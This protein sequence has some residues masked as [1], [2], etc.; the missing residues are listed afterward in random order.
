MP[1]WQPLSDDV[2]KRAF[3][4]HLEVL[5]ALPPGSVTRM[6]VVAPKAGEAAQIFL[7][8]GVR[9]RLE[10]AH[11]TVH[12]NGDVTIAATLQRAGAQYSVLSTIGSEASF[13]TWT[14]PQGSFRFES[15]GTEGW[16]VE[17]DHPQLRVEDIDSHAVGVP[18][19]PASDAL[20]TFK[21]TTTIIDVMFI[22]SAGIAERYPG[23]IAQTRMN[24]LV[25]LANQHFANS[26]IAAV[27]RLAAT[28]QTSYSDLDGPNAVALD[29]MRQALGGL[30][31]H[32]AFEQLEAQRNAAGADI[33]VF[34]RPHDIETRGNCGIAMFPTGSPDV[35][36]HIVSDGFS[37]WSL[38]GDE[39]F[40]HELG[41]NLGAEHQAGANS[42]N[43]GFGT[44]HVV[45]GQFNTVMGSIGSGNPDRNRRLL[46]FSNPQQLCGG[47]PCGQEGVSDNAR[48]I[49]G[50]LA[51]VSGY[52][53]PAAGAPVVEAPPPLD[54]DPDG[55]GVPD[56]QDAFP[57]DARYHSDRDGD[58]VP[59][60]IDTFPDNAAEWADTDGDGIGDNADPDRDGDGVPNAQD[61]F[62]LDS[63]EWQDS[64]GDGVGDNGD[65]F[66][67]DRREWRD[68]DGDGIGDNADSDR[69]GDGVADFHAGSSVAQTD[70]LVVS[71]GTEKVLRFEGNSGLYAGV[72]IAESHVPQ[73]FGTQSNLAWN[74]HQKKLYAL[75]SSELRRYDRASRQRFDRFLGA[76]PTQS[77]FGLPSGFPFG[78]S[79][80]PDGTVLLADSSSSTLWKRDAITGAALGGGVFGTPAF[81][82]QPPRGS[83]LDGAGRLWTLERDGR[84]S[85]VDP[86]TG[87]LL[88]RFTLR[89]VTPPLAFDPMAMVVGPDGR[90]LFIS[91]AR[92]H[93]VLR[94]DPD[95]PDT[96]SVFVAS[97]AGGL[98]APTGLAFGA[99]GHLLVSSSGSDQILRFD[100]ATGAPLGVFSVAPPGALQQP[101]ALLVVP[102]VAD[103]F[104]QDAQRRFRPIAGGWSNPARSGHGLDL[105]ASGSQ[106]GM[107]WYTYDVDGRP[108]WYLGTGALIGDSWTAP[109]L[110]FRWQD[111]AAVSSVVGSVS[112]QFSSERNAVFS[113]VL[114]DSS[115]SE[116]MRP[117][118][119][120]LS[121]ETQY[122]S[123]AW[124]NPQESGWGLS[125]TQQGDLRYAMAFVYD[126][127]G[128]PVWFAGAATDPADPLRIDMQ[129]FFG[130]DRC[131]TCS[132]PRN[133][134]GQP[135]GF[136]S[137]DPQSPGTVQIDADLQ[138]GEVSWLREALQLQRLTDTPT[139]EN[140]DP[141][142]E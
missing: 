5:E 90:S 85:E 76:D 32:G 34:L 65:A 19:K 105:Q 83:A 113:W 126:D 127:D 11:R 38:C 36:V 133:A 42:P 17:L 46:R 110:R 26:D 23:S 69:D 97:V 109:L 10:A 39:V 31:T 137:F 98:A 89:V 84:L 122:P 107:V 100:G 86:A 142:R 6:Q 121:S 104:P 80:L 120:G 114:P 45:P 129:W 106:L 55:D 59:D 15:A 37:S 132:G 78:L 67:A 3:P 33:V 30:V 108:L 136:L 7:P 60:E 138:F 93:R 68:T 112:L 96:S 71:A 115:G 134:E 140:G 48:R 88:R 18:Y 74:P 53:P 139:A 24:H 28:H 47:R 49:R 40:T 54:P 111:G 29:R 130:P 52:L 8:G 141:H 66:P 79:V 20:A 91:D 116:P 117:L 9:H 95:L 73:A 125:I 77:L 131:P 81:F 50:N 92:Q 118:A 44:A 103:R 99:D 101:R 57:F 1:Q 123:A 22:Y 61:A 51:M 16:L 13:G 75:T 102:K 21:N 124:Y 2:A 70:V 135:A 12:P 87:A 4:K 82:A 64:D 63:T 35:G 128:E 119:V 94:V 25:A 14:T 72:E 41:H 62:S 27:A 58:G 56:S 43:A